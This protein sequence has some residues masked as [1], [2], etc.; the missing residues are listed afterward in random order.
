[1]G[2]H[3]HPVSVVG[4][5]GG[6]AGRIRMRGAPGHAAEQLLLPRTMLTV[7]GRHGG[8]DG[9]QAEFVVRS[10]ARSVVA[11]PGASPYRDALALD[12]RESVSVLV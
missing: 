9:G 2:G 4:A 10:P 11:S 8:A 12:I 3:G 1:M 5:G 7:W 6:V